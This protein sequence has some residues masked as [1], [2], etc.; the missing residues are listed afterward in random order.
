MKK[1]LITSIV[2]ITLATSNVVSAGN[3]NK[4][5]GTGKLVPDEYFVTNEERN[6]GRMW[7]SGHLPK[8]GDWYYNND[9]GKYLKTGAFVKHLERFSIGDYDL[10]NSISIN[11]FKSFG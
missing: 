5:Y 1:L 6:C 4:D 10:S 2:G 9:F 3:Y 11:N 8:N 7:A